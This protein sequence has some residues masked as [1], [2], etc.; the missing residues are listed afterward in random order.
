MSN[1]N[2]G[3]LDKVILVKLAGS[4]AGHIYR[5][6][7]E[8]SWRGTISFTTNLL[9]NSY[10]HSYIYTKLSGLQYLYDSGGFDEKIQW[11]RHLGYH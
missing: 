10:S 2:G 3:L 4:F 7:A 1:I 6:S 5:G 9:P 11:D 8:A